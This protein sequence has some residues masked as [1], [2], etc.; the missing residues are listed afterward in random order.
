MLTIE[1]YAKQPREQRM[2]RLTRT[3]DDLSAAIKGQSDAARRPDGKNW[4]ATEVVCH[5]RDTE[6]VF[7][8]RI[9]QILAMDVDP[10]LIAT[11]P[12]RWAEERQYL[13]NDTGKALAAF[14]QR[15][16]ETLETFGKLTP[17][18]WAKGGLHSVAGRITLDGF[19]SIMAWHDDN[20]LDQLMRALQGRA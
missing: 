9:E 19:L 2:Q 6:E 3:A 1:D 18:Q 5:M 7:G 20:H 13:T 17:A 4:A 16:A 10:K 11:N 15:R 12:D 8:A 14:G